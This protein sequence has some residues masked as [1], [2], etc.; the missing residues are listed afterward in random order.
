MIGCN[1]KRF[2]GNYSDSMLRYRERYDLLQPGDAANSD[3]GTTSYDTANGMICC[4]QAQ[5]VTSK[6]QAGYDTANGM[7]CCNPKRICAARST[8]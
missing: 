8:S 7:I 6:P 4:N 1:S 3:V 5:D 2:V